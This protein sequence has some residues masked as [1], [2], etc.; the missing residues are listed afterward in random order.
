[1]KLKAAEAEGGATQVIEAKNLSKSFDEKHVV[2]DFSMRVL[3]GNRVGIVGANGAG[4]TTLLN[5]LIGRLKPDAGNAKI[6]SNVKLAVLDQNRS[7]LDP[8]TIV[9]AVLTDGSGDMV[10]VGGKSRH[11]VSYM[12]D[13]LFAPAQA[14]APVRVLSGGERARLLLAKILAAPSNLLVLDEPTND[15]DLETLDLLEE[16]LSQY[17]GTILVVSH[18][19]DFLDRVVSSV[20]MAEGD[21]KFVEYAGGYSDMFAQRGRGVVSPELKG[22]KA[23]KNS[24]RKAHVRTDK[25]PRNKPPGNKSPRKMSFKDKHALETLPTRITELEEEIAELNAQLADAKFYARDPDGF[26][27]ASAKLEQTQKSLSDAEERWLE[28]ETLREELNQN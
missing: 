27:K 4:K 13:F 3:R 19:R 12:K 20:L 9:S 5:M 26:S 22:T 2:R 10:N 1:V 17:P 6:A 16:M 21:G 18:D 7:A 25:S 14:R 23:N 15:L 8:E 28:L 11:V 24:A